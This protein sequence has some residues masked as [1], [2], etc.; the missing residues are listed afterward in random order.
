MEEQHHLVLTSHPPKG[1]AKPPDINWGANSIPERGPII[2][3]LLAPEQR[4]VI[5]VHSGAYG[6]YRALSVAAG[7]LDPIH[8]PDLTNTSPATEIGPF[9]Q[10]RSPKKIVS[11]DPWG[12]LVSQSFDKELKKGYDIRPTIAVTKARISFPEIRESIAGKR[13]QP[14]GAVLHTNGDVSV[15]KVAIE[16]VW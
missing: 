13:L 10:W 9:P 3:S 2:G 1:A 8:K 7:Q 16:P 12:H 5:G 14:D 4:N 6:V 15:T 11:L